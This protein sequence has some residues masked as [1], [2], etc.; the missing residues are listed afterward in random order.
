MNHE[1][2]PKRTRACVISPYYGASRWSGRYWLPAAIGNWL[3]D[4]IGMRESAPR[5]LARFLCRFHGGPK[6]LGRSFTILRE[7]AKLQ[8]ETGL[9]ANQL[10]GAIAK[11]KAIGFIREVERDGEDW[12]WSKVWG[13][14]IRVAS[15]FIFSGTIAQMLRY[16]IDRKSARRP[17]PPVRGTTTFGGY[18]NSRTPKAAPEPQRSTENPSLHL[19]GGP[20]PKVERVVPED[21]RSQ[22][23]EAMNEAASPLMA[24]LARM[25]E[26]MR[27]VFVDDPKK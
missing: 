8:T 26:A 9:S 17:Q 22:L 15:R 27:G 4:E 20:A 7:N 16:M 2:L 1:E 25:R 6:N 21:R 23:D 18:N 24:A 14:A 3:D 19:T 5:I 13:K 11:L 10:R 12:R